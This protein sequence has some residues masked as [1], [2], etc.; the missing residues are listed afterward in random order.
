MLAAFYSLYLGLQF[1]RKATFSL[2]RHNEAFRPQVCLIMPC[3]GKE[4]GLET[5][6]EA[7]LQQTYHNYRMV[8]ITDSSEDPAYA[9]AKSTLALHPERDCQLYTTKVSSEASGKVAALLTALAREWG[10]ADAFVFIDS[11]ALVPI[12]WLEDLIQPLKDELVGAATGFRWYFAT[13]GGFW[14]YVQ[15][16]WNASGTNLLFNDHYNFPW[17]GAMAIRAETLE[18]I[19]IRQ[20]WANAVSDDL[21]LNSALRKYG[22]SVSFLPQ[23]TV[24]TFNQ[25]NQQ[26]FLKWATRQ[27]TL[28]KFFN[29]GLWNYALAAYAFFDFV[30]LLGVVSLALGAILGLGWLAPSALLFTLPVFGIVGS[31][32]RNLAFSRAM[33]EFSNEFRRTRLGEAIASLIVPWVMTY[34]LIKSTRTDLIEWRGRTYRLS[35]MKPVASPRSIS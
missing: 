33:P 11:D 32:Q 3:K 13:Q 26:D 25:T 18:K 30:F 29:R 15:A 10:K 12:R 27:T 23:C 35:G 28:T 24:A 5:N 31:V 8:I 34:C 1:D 22:Y 2:N 21:T 7:A 17:G 9:V 20:E 14:S 6:I 19:N 4:Q 16:A